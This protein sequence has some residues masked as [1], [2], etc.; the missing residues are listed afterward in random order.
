MGSGMTGRQS[1]GLMGRSR[2]G[3]QWHEGEGVGEVGEFRGVG[4]GVDLAA[5][6][7]FG[8]QTRLRRAARGLFRWGRGTNGL[9]IARARWSQWRHPMGRTSRWVPDGAQR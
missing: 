6:A 5:R 2:F 3:G 9:R 4:Y 7:L 8:N 1:G